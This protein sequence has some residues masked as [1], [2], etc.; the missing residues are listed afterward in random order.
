MSVAITVIPLWD[1]LTSVLWNNVLDRVSLPP[2]N[3]PKW[4]YVVNSSYTLGPITTAHLSLPLIW[5]VNLIYKWLKSTTVVGYNPVDYHRRSRCPCNDQ[6]GQEAELLHHS[7][8]SPPFSLLPPSIEPCPS[9]VVC[10]LMWRCTVYIGTLALHSF[11]CVCLQSM[12]SVLYHWMHLQV[13][14]CRGDTLASLRE[15]LDWY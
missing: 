15:A 11:Q 9:V 8:L 3:N 6:S 2:S 12:F 10:L 4:C 7:P 14:V 5:K 13:I 1:K